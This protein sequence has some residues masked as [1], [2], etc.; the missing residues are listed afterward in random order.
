G[1]DA[2]GLLQPYGGNRRRILAP[3][4]ARFHGSVLLLI[5][6]EPPRIRTGLR[7][8]GRRQH[9]PAIVFLRVGQLYHVH[10]EAIA[11]RQWQGGRLCGAAPARAAGAPRICDDGITS[12]VIA[13]GTW[14]AA[15][16]ARP[17]PLV[18][19]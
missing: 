8:D 7:A 19:G 17:S 1:R 9:R 12:R 11:R 5:G 18:L 10:H 13:P 6:L 16:L 15:S 4:E 14:V 3:A 2:F